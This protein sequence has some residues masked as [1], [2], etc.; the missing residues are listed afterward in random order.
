[1]DWWALV[2]MGLGIG[3]AGVVVVFGLCFGLVLVLKLQM[4]R[5]VCTNFNHKDQFCILC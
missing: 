4:V 5:L 3:W 2:N 1:M